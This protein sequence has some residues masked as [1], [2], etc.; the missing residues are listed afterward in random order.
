[1]TGYWQLYNW[2]TES[3]RDG[4]IEADSLESAQQHAESI[5]PTKFDNIEWETLLPTPF[6]YKKADKHHFYLDMNPFQIPDCVTN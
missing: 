6:A 1:M 5:M 3:F 2:N 4:I